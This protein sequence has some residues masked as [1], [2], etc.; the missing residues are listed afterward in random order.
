[1]DSDSQY[2]LYF[3]TVFLWA[4]VKLSVNA[5]GNSFDVPL[6]FKSALLRDI[7]Q[8]RKAAFMKDNSPVTWSVSKFR[9]IP[10]TNV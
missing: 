4:E 6:F 2:I 8:L 10:N 7:V 5:A 3:G 9:H 1:M